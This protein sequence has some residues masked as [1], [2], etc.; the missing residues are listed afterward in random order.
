MTKEKLVE[1]IDFAKQLI[2][3]EVPQGLSKEDM[4]VLKPY[5]DQGIIKLIKKKVNYSR[6]VYFPIME[7][8]TFNGI[9]VDFARVVMKELLA[10]VG[11][12]VGLSK[13]SMADYMSKASYEYG[14]S[15]TLLLRSEAGKAQ[16]LL[17]KEVLI[18]T[19]NSEA[20]YSA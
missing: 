10:E 18:E 5:L 12:P 1:A 8:S 13:H 2:A 16:K 4:T 7:S 15:P 17:E 9:T 3:S 11:H 19:F 6:Q 20:G 14:I